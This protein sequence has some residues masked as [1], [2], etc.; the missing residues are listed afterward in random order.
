MNSG[1]SGSAPEPPESNERQRRGMNNPR[2]SSLTGPLLLKLFV[3]AAINGFALAG[4]PTMI[5]QRFWFGVATVVIATLA[6]DFVYLTR[7]AIPAK[8]LIPGTIFALVFQ[9]YPVIYSGY[10][11]F[12]NFSTSNRLSFDQALDQFTRRTSDV[13][14]SVRYRL[15]ILGADDGAGD[16]AFYLTDEAGNEFLGTSEGLEE[17]SQDRI[18]VD[19]SGDVESV[20]EYVVLPIRQVADR[21]QEIENTF[22]V[23]TEGGVIKAVTLNSA[24]VYGRQ[25]V[26]DP[27]TGRLTS[28]ETG[29][30]YEQVDGRF[31]SSSGQFLQPGWTTYVGFANFTRIFT[32]EAIRGP[33]I[34][35][36]IWNFVFATLS[37]ITT[38]AV[39]LGLA[40]AL[41]HPAMRGRKIYRSLLI[42]PYALP[43]FMTALIW[44]GIFNQDFGILNRALGTSIP[45]LR[46]PT[47][48]KVSVLIVNLWLGF[49][50]MF[51]ISTGALQAIPNELTE[52]ALVD[53]ANPRQ[54]FRGVTFPLLL[55]SLAP[56]LIASFA[57]NF[58]NFN[59]IYLLNGGGP[60]IEGAQTPAGHTDILIS[61]TYRLAFESG[62]GADFGFASA[63]AIIIFVLVATISGLSY[64]KTRV[65]EEVV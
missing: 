23:P 21:Q 30:V 2:R 62:R 54:A 25:F 50:Y 16:L 29:E 64:R 39:G 51:L 12:T 56:L 1:P 35:V 65:L 46:D 3:L 27:D 52:A 57:F 53:G 5:S 9:V 8:Y 33:F 10:I 6:I 37:V 44:A 41:N 47:M 13:P 4:L 60:P 61:Y 42:L 15:T 48:A 59:I 20:D 24:A 49:P 55:V 28:N 45:W 19:D 11:A 43:S 32:S 22:E 26:Y 34:R 58:N 31:T 18:V 38:F 40:L 17:L 14:G 63:I 7:R 36:F